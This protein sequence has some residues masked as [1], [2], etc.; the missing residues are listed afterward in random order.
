VAGAEVVQVYVGD[1]K[2]SVKRPTRE[3]KGFRKVF[4]RPGESRRLSF[5]LDERA[6]S[7]YDAKK[8]AWVAEKGLF[9][10][11]V[12]A[13]SRDIRLTGCFQLA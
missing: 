13:S 11:E 6:L 1:P 9:T 2:A 5:I 3:L 12:G 4:L 10:V 8:K 7:F